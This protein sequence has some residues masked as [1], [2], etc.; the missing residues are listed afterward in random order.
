V[1]LV[2][3][4]FAS[5]DDGCTLALWDVLA[6][7]STCEVWR[8]LRGHAHVPG[9]A[10][11]GHFSVANPTW[12]CEPVETTGGGNMA[13]SFETIAPENGRVWIPDLVAWCWYELWTVGNWRAA[14]SSMHPG[15]Q[16]LLGAEGRKWR[17]W[18][19]EGYGWVPEPLL[20]EV[21]IIQR[22]GQ[23]QKAT[24]L[25]ELLVALDRAGDGI[26]FGGGGGEPGILPI[27]E[28]WRLNSG[29]LQRIAP[30]TVLRKATSGYTGGAALD[31]YLQNYVVCEER[32]AILE[33]HPLVGYDSFDSLKDDLIRVAFVPTLVCAKDARFS[34]GRHAEE[35]TVALDEDAQRRL[36]QSADGLVA[37]LEARQVNI[38]IFPE[39]CVSVESVG[40]LQQALSASAARKGSTRCLR[41]VFVGVCA[42]S[43]GRGP[44]YNCVYVYTGHG[45]HICT[46]L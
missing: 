34:A 33:I 44:T 27:L 13:F 21:R 43:R 3:T 29:K 24:A 1:G 15:D 17:D 10:G 9:T 32:D 39:G 46:R 16:A 5:L 11:N 4:N 22:Q 6:T 42:S 26:G 38:A 8:E 14:F 45:R 37:D 20:D 40:A 41:L 28:R 7:L 31:Q 19:R 30:A 23:N 12:L 2:R 18:A 36:K 35:F 25:L